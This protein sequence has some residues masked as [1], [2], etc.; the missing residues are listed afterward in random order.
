MIAPVGFSR[1]DEKSQF[2]DSMM[3]LVGI[4][5]NKEPGDCNGS[6]IV[7]ESVMS[8]ASVDVYFSSTIGYTTLAILQDTPPDLVE[9]IRGKIPFEEVGDENRTIVFLAVPLSDVF[10]YTLMTASP[11]LYGCRIHTIIRDIEK[12][13]AIRTL[14]EVLL[15]LQDRGEIIL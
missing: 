12:D 6:V 1:D 13:V 4:D 7:F 8:N 2:N 14:C 9:M 10:E 3:K 5:P 11:I 15:D